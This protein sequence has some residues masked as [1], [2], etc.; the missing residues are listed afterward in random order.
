MQR[1]LFFITTLLL[2]LSCAPS[3]SYHE[4]SE[5]E[6]HYASLLRLHHLSEGVELCRIIDPWH[7]DKFLAQYLL[8]ADTVRELDLSN[9]ELVYGKS[10]VL[11]TPLKKLTLTN[12][13][14]AYL[15]HELGA[16]DRIAVICDADYVS[17]IPIRSMLADQKITKGG[18]SMSP[19]IETIL[20]AGC[21]AIWIS[22]FE[23]AAATNV[24]TLPL[25]TILCA[26]YMET[27]PMARAEWMK[28]Y[29]LLVGCKS[30]ADSLFTLVEER[31]LSLQKTNNNPSKKKKILT[32]T[33][34]QA[35]WYVPGGNSTKAQLFADA[36][37]D[38]PWFD[39]PHS[40]SVALSQEEVLTR[41][42]D[43]DVWLI[44][45]F[46]D[47][48]YTLSE[49]LTFNP[50]YPQFKAAQ[51][52]EVYG[53]NTMATDFYDVTPFRPDILLEEL[54]EHEGRYYKKL[55]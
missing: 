50:Y 45:Y 39:D 10:L 5:T 14:H 29:G 24:S 30:Q 26:D 12:S 4:T 46:A 48:D 18:S 1:V 19:N 6:T 32:E 17:Y 20:A 3:K 47:H 7:T 54:T 11:R 35:T 36:G 22:P 49:F 41:A 53:C 16:S 34:Y 55:R 23:N 37:F 31:Y 52:G 44:S 33:P 9:I 21:D 40:G 42:K 38:Y 2:V 28:F 51:I 25:P 8:V 15:L 13:C 43:A 27:S